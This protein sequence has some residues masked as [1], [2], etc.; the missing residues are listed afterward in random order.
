M[1][2]LVDAVA[3]C[4]GPATVL[5]HVLRHWRSTFQHVTLVG[6][7]TTIEH[8]SRTN[9]VDEY[10]IVDTEDLIAI[11]RNVRGVWDVLVCVQNPAGFPALQKLATHTVYWDFLLWMRVGDP[12]AEFAA[13]R[14]VV[15]NYPGSTDALNKWGQWI[16]NP[17]LCPVLAKWSHNPRKDRTGPVIVNLGGQRS[18][19]TRPGDN[20]QYPEHVMNALGL[21]VDSLSSSTTILI[22]AD[23]QTIKDLSHRVRDRDW[24]FVSLGHQEFLN[25]VANAPLLITHPGLYSPFEAIGLGTPTVFLP[26]SNYTQV[27]QLAT[28]R[29]C[30]LAPWAIDWIDLVGRTVP[31]GLQES[32]GVREVLQLVSTLDDV[33]ITARLVNTLRCWLSLADKELRIG[34]AQQRDAAVRYY[35][36]VDAFM[37]RL[38]D[39]LVGRG[40]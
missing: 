14:Y 37:Q 22:C 24:T 4:Y 30:G 3:F 11:E 20:T 25:A 12:G 26:S 28:F 10:I 16:A 19:L 5:H 32:E 15:E 7:G 34:G 38:L 35:G 17:I 21:A 8:M 27:L 39:G 1:R 33:E 9:L 18:K 36:D 40:G 13:D 31:A 29:E 6:T 23:A 2:L